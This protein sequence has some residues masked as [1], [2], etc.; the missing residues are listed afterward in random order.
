II[1]RKKP[2]ALVCAFDMSGP[3]FRH[4]LYDL[5]KA[6]RGEMPEALAA[7]LP[8]I[9]QVLAAMAIPVLESPG[10]EADDVLATIARLCE[11]GGARCL[12]VTG[13]KDARQLLSPQVAVYNIRKDH[14]YG[15]PELFGDWGIEPQQVVDFQALVGD[16]VDNVPGVPLIGPK[17]AKDLLDQ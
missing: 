13:D 11:E 2:T 16:K 4:E 7:Q 12:L 1:E 6:E 14:E 10:Y 9:R 5:Y 8:K 17:A 15:A 3:T